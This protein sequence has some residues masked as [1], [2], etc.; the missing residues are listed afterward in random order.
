MKISS[1]GRYGLRA[2]Y[3]IGT[4]AKDDYVPVT[5]L[6][7]YI[8]TTD[9]YLE[10]LMAILKKN[11]LVVSVRGNNG[12]YKLARKPEYISVG[13]ILRSLENGIFVTECVS[14]C[15]KTECPHKDI[16]THIYQSINDVLDNMSL[17][18]MIDRTKGK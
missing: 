2:M 6:A 13:Q 10:K 12:G 16:F 3:Y 18:D 1:K 17:K 7:S 8:G 11:D 5:T 4:L 15:K 14:G 9:N